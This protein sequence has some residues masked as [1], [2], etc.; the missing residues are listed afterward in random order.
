MSARRRSALPLAAI[1]LA[2]VAAL[3]PRRADAQVLQRFTLRG[4]LGAT[5]MLADLQRDLLGYDFGAQGTLRVGFTL[6]LS[7]IHI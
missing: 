7:L 1:A 2:A 3:A 4:E 6:T 5:V